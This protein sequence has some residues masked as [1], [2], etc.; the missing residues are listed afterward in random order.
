MNAKERAL[1]ASLIRHGVRYLDTHGW[2]HYGIRGVAGQAC[3]IHSLV[4]SAQALGASMESKVLL[5]ACDALDEAAR[6]LDRSELAEDDNLGPAARY[7]EHPNRNAVEVKNFMGH[8]A[9]ELAN[10]RKGKSSVIK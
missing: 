4:L 10:T 9:N 3:M 8:V 1:A 6:K 5:N 2:N 7:N